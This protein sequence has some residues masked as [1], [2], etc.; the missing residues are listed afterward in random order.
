MSIK[1]LVKDIGAKM[2]LSR[3]HKIILAIGVLYILVIALLASIIVHETPQF[4]GNVTSASEVIGINTSVPPLARWDSQWYWSIAERGYRSTEYVSQ[5]NIN[6]MPLYPVLMRFT[7]ELLHINLFTSGLLVSWVTFLASLIAIYS[8]ARSIG[9][10]AD[11]GTKTI[12]ALLAF[13]SAFIF[14][15]VYS[16]SL[17]LLLTA[18]SLLLYRK[19]HPYYSALTAFLATSTRI[20]GLALSGAYAVIAFKKWRQH[21]LHHSDIYPVVAPVLVVAI[22]MIYCLIVFNDPLRFVH[23]K[24]IQFAGRGI[25]WPWVTIWEAVLTFGRFLTDINIYTFN[26]GFGSIA[27]LFAIIG[28]ALLWKRKLYLEAGYVTAA[29]LLI[30]QTG[31]SWGAGRYTVVL[32][33]LFMIMAKQKKLSQRFWLWYLFILIGI[34]WQIILLWNYVTFT[35]LSP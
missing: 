28:C 32:F 7:G 11:Q 19:K 10:T 24:A 25:N 16:E 18:S 12:I 29:L 20:T 9:H 1:H 15:S 26:P 30:T 6:F 21:K 4:A 35:S 22:K 31:S 27:L 23:V 13:P 8:Y 5:Y 2:S 14:A 3:Q 33:P 17:F 34:F